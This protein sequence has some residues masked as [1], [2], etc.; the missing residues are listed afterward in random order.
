MSAGIRPSLLAPAGLVA[1]FAAA[2]ATGRR[3]LGG[4]VFGVAGVLCARDWAKAAGAPAAA[5]LVAC[6]AAALG[7]SHPLAK[8]IGAWP[9]VAAVSA[10]M[11]GASGLL[12]GLAARA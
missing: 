3:E 1:G 5:V 2:Q 8:R 7:G 9:A 11:A 6:Y 4:A 10:A 12:V